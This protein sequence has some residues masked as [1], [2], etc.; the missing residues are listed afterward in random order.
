MSA[1]HAQQRVAGCLTTV[2]CLTDHAYVV[3]DA[4]L[5]ASHCSVALPSKVSGSAS[6]H[7]DALSC[8]ALPAKVRQ[9]L[10]GA[11]L[12]LDVGAVCRVDV[13]CRQWRCYE[14]GYP[15]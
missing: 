15:A 11:L 10:A 1:N 12:N 3:A 8:H 7:P 4:A 14:E 13:D 6:A 9:L 2:H 5:A